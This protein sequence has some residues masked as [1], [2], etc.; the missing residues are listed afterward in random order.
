MVHEALPGAGALDEAGEPNRDRVVTRL[1]YP[2]ATGARST[3]GYCD[4]GGSR[5]DGSWLPNEGGEVMPTQPE[6]A[7][8]D[9][10]RRR[11][12]L[13]D[14]GL[15]YPIPM[16]AFHRGHVE[17]DIHARYDRVQHVVVEY[18]GEYWHG[19]STDVSDAHKTRALLHAG[20]L[21]VR[22][23]D[24]CDPLQLGQPGLLQV[25]IDAGR[26]LED[27]QAQAIVAHVT[28]WLDGQ[29]YRE[30]SQPVALRDAAPTPSTRR[31]WERRQFGVRFS[32]RPD[33]E[34]DLD[35]SPDRT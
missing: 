20:Y 8:F 30:A 24:R 18:D 7:L 3:I 31:P 28:D 32:L 12:P 25:L 16:P 35:G 19:G 15:R 14:L 13:H 22:V 1:V 11:G 34:A 5:H 4:V 27:H 21:V 33:E 10:F 26:M 9:A 23:R 6:I 2:T 29:Q 17:V